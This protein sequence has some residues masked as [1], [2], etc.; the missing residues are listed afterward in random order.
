[1]RWNGG[2][3]LGWFSELISTSWYCSIVRLSKIVFL[4]R[5][6]LNLAKLRPGNIIQSHNHHIKK[7]ANLRQNLLIPL[8]K[9]E[10]RLKLL[11]TIV[12]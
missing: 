11:P 8:I 2:R 10:S 9:V 3:L 4:L 1:M 5:P 12:V 6:N 7:L